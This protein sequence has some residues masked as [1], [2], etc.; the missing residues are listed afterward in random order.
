[1]GNLQTTAGDIILDETRPFP[2]Q[3]EGLQR[4][5]KPYYPKA[6]KIPWWLAEIAYKYYSARYGT[7][8]S[9]ELLGQR[10]G[11]GR[12]ELM[13][14]IQRDED[15][16]VESVTFSP[17]DHLPF[18]ITGGKILKPCTV[19]WWLAEIAWE[20]YCKWPGATLENMVKLGGFTRIELMKLLG[21]SIMNV[22]SD[23]EVAFLVGSFDAE[24]GCQC[25][26][27]TLR[28]AIPYTAVV[29]QTA[30]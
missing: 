10:G 12:Y 1:M 18:P 5:P 25:V 8:Q 17:E 6:S 28:A 27:K 3:G 4:K 19:P 30:S 21:I 7:S 26:Q 22:L 11:F 24:A 20:N 9:L 16:W 14:Y 13:T 23:R 29:Q 15:W 2:I